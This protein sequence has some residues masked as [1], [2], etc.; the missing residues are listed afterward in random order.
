PAGVPL[1]RGT[2]AQGVGWRIPVGGSQAIADAVVADRRAHG[3]EVR[4]GVRVRTWRELPRARTYLL[5]TSPWAAAE[6]WGERLPP[7]VARRLRDAARGGGAAKVDFVLDGPVPWAVPGVGRGFTA[8]HGGGRAA[9]AAAAAGL[10][11]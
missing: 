11:R 10:R 4:T 2:L 6:I 8:H 9:L 5:D 3:G 7:S 1:M